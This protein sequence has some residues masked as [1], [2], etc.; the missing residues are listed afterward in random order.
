VVSRPWRPG[1]RDPKR[2]PAVVGHAVAYSAPDGAFKRREEEGER[3]GVVPDVGAGPLAA[4][5]P[6]WQ[7][8][9]NRGCRPAYDAGGGSGSWQPGSR[10]RRARSRAMSTRIVRRK[11]AWSPPEACRVLGE[12]AAATARPEA[13]GVVV[14]PARLPVI[15]VP[16]GGSRSRP[17]ASIPH[18]GN[19]QVTKSGSVT[20]SPDL[21][22][23]S[24]RASRC[25]LPAAGTSGR[26]PRPRPHL[27]QN[28]NRFSNQHP[29]PRPRVGNV[30]VRGE[31]PH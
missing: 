23:P 8:R 16:S 10:R 9:T 1:Y 2:H 12:K 4:A 20:V 29:R 3:L 11:N 18:R 25:P 6:Q 13:P 21:W 17:A 15:A 22:P 28:V 19:D 14:L 31:H 24:S 5:V 7:P 27:V 26:R 30:R